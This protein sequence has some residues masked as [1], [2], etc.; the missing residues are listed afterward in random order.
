MCK[1]KLGFFL[2]LCLLLL[3]LTTAAIAAEAEVYVASTGSDTAAGTADAPVATLEKAMT[4]LQNGGTVKLIDDITLAPTAGSYFLEPAHSGKITVTSAD[5]RDKG[6]ILFTSA[7]KVYHF[8]GEGEWNNIRVLANITSGVHISGENNKVTMGEGLEML[9]TDGSTAGTQGGHTFAGTKIYLFSSFYVSDGHTAA[10][11]GNVGGGELHIYSGEYWYVGGWR[12][13]GTTITGGETLLEIGARDTSTEI[14]INTLT[15]TVCNTGTY[16]TMAAD[17]NGNAPRS[18]V[19]IGD[20]V[21]C[22]NTYRLSQ[23]SLTGTVTVDYIFKGAIYGD[24]TARKIQNGTLRSPYSFAVNT[25][26]DTTDA[27]VV[28]DVTTFLASWQTGV[29]GDHDIENTLAQYCTANGHNFASGVCSC[30]GVTVCDVTGHT[31]VNGVCSACGREESAVYVASSGNDTAAGSATAPVATLARAYALLGDKGGTIKLLDVVTVVANSGTDFIEPAHSGKITLTSADVSK[32]GGLL[33]TDTCKSF[34]FGGDG[35]WNNILVQADYTGGII[36]SCENNDVTMGE[37]LVMSHTTGATAGTVGGH[38]FSA[39]KVYLYSGFKVSG[40]HTA[41]G[42]EHVAG[43]SLSVYSG[44]YWWIGGWSGYDFTVTGGEGSIYVG[45]QNETD[46]IWTNNLCPADSN[47]SG[48]KAF[49]AAV[50]EKGAAPHMTV[51]VGDG[52]NCNYAYRIT[53]GRLTGT[54]TVDWILQGELYGESTQRSSQTFTLVSPC[55]ITVNVYLDTENEGVVADATTFLNG[56][57]ATFGGDHDI[58]NTLAQYCALHGHNFVVSDVSVG[59]RCR[60]CEVGICAENGH[61]FTSGIC[62]YCKR[63]EHASLLAADGGYICADC[64]ETVARVDATLIATVSDAAGTAGGNATVEIALNATDFW[65]SMWSVD[66]LEGFTLAAFE[67]AESDDF[68]VQGAAELGAPYRFAV[69]NS[70]VENGSVQKTVA[71]LRLQ[72]AETVAAGAYAVTLTPIEAYDADGAA[73]TALGIGGRVAVTVAEEIRG[74]LNDDGVVTIVDV[75]LA[76]REVLNETGSDAVDLNG[77]GAVSLV[78]VIRL[79]KLCAQ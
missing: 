47:V 72:M 28:T 35:E 37:G 56:W 3:A 52:V 26:L 57:S 45:T 48:S 33:F 46:V 34:Y 31:Y 69:L 53:Q 41:V 25:Y 21:N 9:H 2:F 40:A 5:A 63:A 32:K 51:V 55:T 11:I 68:L 44:E 64:G 43:G 62:L 30:C 36:I 60:C 16:V 10:N 54:L 13:S 42:T 27:A 49:A 20:G 67:A 24:S 4:M 58:E 29:E 74:D 65:G 39:T 61:T 18:T 77:D 70:T 50:D 1:N 7:C 8:N 6:G 19:I 14:W 79:L 78:D 38:T 66:L 71:T 73:L 12:A 17:A 15:G 59:L 76:L 75:L 23:G 22:N